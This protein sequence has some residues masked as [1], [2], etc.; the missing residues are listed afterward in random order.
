MARKPKSEGESDAFLRDLEAG[1][2]AVLSSKEA[3]PSE[4]VQAINAGAKIA[5]IKHKISGSDEKG[6]FDV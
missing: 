3:S 6:F 2:R 5:M 4:R 1:V